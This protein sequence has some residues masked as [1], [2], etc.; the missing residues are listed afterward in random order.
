MTW[1]G[2]GG[3]AGS[4]DAQTWVVATVVVVVRLVGGAGAGT[5]LSESLLQLRPILSRAYVLYQ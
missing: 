3:E 2:G 4:L 5:G 1:V